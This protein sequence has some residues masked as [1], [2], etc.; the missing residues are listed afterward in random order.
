MGTEISV[1][2]IIII[3]AI[4]I[5]YSHIKENEHTTSY[6]ELQGKYNYLVLRS[7][8]M[9]KEYEKLKEKLEITEKNLLE[10]M[11]LCDI[12]CENLLI[13]EK[14]ILDETGYDFDKLKEELNNDGEELLLFIFDNEY[15]E[16]SIS[17]IEDV[18]LNKEPLHRFIS[19]RI[20]REYVVATDI[21]ARDVWELHKILI[22][23]CYL[24]ESE[25]E[26][27]DSANGGKHWIELTAK[28][29][30]YIKYLMN[31]RKPVERII[32][33]PDS[34]IVPGSLLI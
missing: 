24:K 29:R 26:K 7:D 28:A 22:K 2:I 1:T 11:K 16:Y 19:T 31:D 30:F 34:S 18:E 5:W 25:F 33:Y 4:F 10:D 20:L 21:K 23:L 6:Q 8:S 32:P 3:I 14:I 17:N 9:K 27:N 13:A 15:S 12:F